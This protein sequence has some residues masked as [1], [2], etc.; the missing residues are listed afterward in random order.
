M[1]FFVKIITAPNFYIFFNIPLRDL[2]NLKPTQ[3][4]PTLFNR[5]CFRISYQGLVLITSIVLCIY[6]RKRMSNNRTGISFIALPA[7]ANHLLPS[8]NSIVP[9]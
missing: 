9:V 5:K 4:A 3:K 1:L 2:L 6:A 7:S 8:P